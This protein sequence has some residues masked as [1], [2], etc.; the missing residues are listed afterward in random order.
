MLLVTNFVKERPFTVAPRGL[1]PDAAPWDDP[2]APLADL[3]N[4]DS[5]SC[6]GY[7]VKIEIPYGDTTV[8]T[9]ADWIRPLGTL[10]VADSPVLDDVPAAVLDGLAHPMGGPPL[11]ERL[12]SG[13]SVV[14]VVSD[15]FRKT[16]VDQILPTLLTWL[17]ERGVGEEHI[18]F[19]V[20]TGSH[21]GPTGDELDTI[22]GQTVHHR[23]AGRIHS[24]DPLDRDNLVHVGTTS[25]GTPVS[26][27]KI[28]AKAD[29][30]IVTGTVVLHYF[31]G[32]GGGRKSIV[33]GLAGLETIAAN[34]ALNLDPFEDTLNPDV[35]IGRMSGNPVAEDMLE[36]ALLGPDAF[37]INTVLDRKG[38]IA[39]IFMGDLVEAHNVAC[40]F[41]A[42]LYSVPIQEQADLVI[43]SAGTA[44]NFIQ[45]HK[46]LYN[47]CQ[48]AKPGGLILLATPAE[49]GYGGNKFAEWLALGSRGAII[50][51]LRR[52]AEI[53]GQTA[54]S[55][56]EKARRTVFLTRMAP[57]L[58]SAM[59]GRRV[60]SLADG[61]EMLRRDFVR[62]GIEHP[63]GLV[64]PSASVT[65]PMLQPH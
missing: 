19:L 5:T 49:E 56:L 15:S 60:D 25:R 64:M 3:R 10:E 65:V 36:G 33:P 1:N 26:L 16:C 40:A 18:T 55:T 45:S 32:F 17:G 12:R 35:A 34:H 43:A 14:I 51:A 59:G 48:A 62:A 9:V 41:S 63:T 37:L 39:R 24:H 2:D 21:R 53:N 7:L 28:A 31:G 47:A 38:K 57:E 4:R 54:L 58:V 23:F 22:L 44:K 20:A 52:N 61:L 13:G 27:N 42:S 30:L 11:H 6:Y 50:A 46:S 29:T 8:E